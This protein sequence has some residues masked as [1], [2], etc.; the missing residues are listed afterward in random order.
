MARRG[1]LG[2]EHW[3]R[4]GHRPGAAAPPRPVS[5]RPPGLPTPQ[6]PPLTSGLWHRCVCVPRRGT[7]SEPRKG[8]R[9]LKSLC[10][11]RLGNGAHPPRRERRVR[12]ASG[13]RTL[14]LSALHISSSSCGW[15]LPPCRPS[16]PLSPSAFESHLLQEAFRHCHLQGAGVGG[17]HSS[18]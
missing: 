3:G 16:P 13:H 8:G 7:S 10:L 9:G 14:P 15:S 1:G 12:P 2:P 6:V 11:R 18:L 17:G 5:H 4:G